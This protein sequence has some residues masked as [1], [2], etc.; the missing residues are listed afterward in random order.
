MKR[1][2]RELKNQID[3]EEIYIIFSSFFATRYRQHSEK[4]IK[5]ALNT[6]IC[7]EGFLNINIY[8]AKKMLLNN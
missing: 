8:N 3:Y 1:K 2:K 4:L 5:E 6:S 7:P